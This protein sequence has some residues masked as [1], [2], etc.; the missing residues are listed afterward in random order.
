MGCD[1][2][3][4][5]FLVSGKYTSPDEFMRRMGAGGAW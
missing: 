1:I 2:H 3:V 5:F 4:V